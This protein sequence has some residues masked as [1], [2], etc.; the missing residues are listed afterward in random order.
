MG[1]IPAVV[2]SGVVVWDG[3]PILEAAQARQI[4][5]PVE[6]RAKRLADDEAPQAAAHEAEV[7]G[8]VRRQGIV[9]ALGAVAARVVQEN[10]ASLQVPG[11]RPRHRL[12]L[13]ARRPRRRRCRQ[14]HGGDHH[15]CPDLQLTAKK[16]HILC[17]MCNL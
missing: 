5:D 7:D 17:R 8:G 11:A 14:H 16:S 9:H 4:G 2:D 6:V 13:L 10:Q 1:R 12:Q 3:A 15:H